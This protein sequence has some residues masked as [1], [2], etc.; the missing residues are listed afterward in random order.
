MRKT[1]IRRSRKS[2]PVLSK[3]KQA[4]LGN[5]VAF[6]L[7]GNGR[8]AALIQRSEGGAFGRQA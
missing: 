1:A 8:D 7:S 4:A 3:L 5:R 6:S 2:F